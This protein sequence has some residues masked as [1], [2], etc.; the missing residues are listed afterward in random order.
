MRYFTFFL[1]TLFITQTSFSQEKYERE[2]RIKEKEVPKSA[3]DFMKEINFSRKIRWYKEFAADKTSIEG[4]TKHKRKY[5]SIEFDTFG[6]IEDVEIQI[7]LKEIPSK[8]YKTIIRFFDEE[9]NNY[10]I[11]KNQLQYSGKQENLL[12]K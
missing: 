6:N 7:K 4:K 10:L 5:Y 11:E 9:Y 8:T 12:K 2:V 1:F 3:I